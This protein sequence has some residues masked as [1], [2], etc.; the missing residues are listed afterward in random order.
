MAAVIGS[1][2][3]KHAQKEL[4]IDHVTLWSDSQ[5]V[6]HWLSST[7]TL[8]RFVK[9]RVIEIRTLLPEHKWRYCP[10]LDN[11]ADLL[12]RGLSASQFM[13]NE[14]WFKGPSW[15]TDARSWPTWEPQSTTVCLTEACC[16]PITQSSSAD[17]PHVVH[18]VHNLMHLTEYSSLQRLLRVTA[19]VL[20]F[21][22]N[23]RNRSRARPLTVTSSELFESEKQWIASCQRITYGEEIQCITETSSRKTLVKQLKLFIDDSGLLRCGGRIHNAP[24]AETTKFPY[25]LPQKHLFTRLVV[26][27]AH[28]RLLHSGPNATIIFLRQKYWIPAIRRCVQHVLHR[29]VPCRR[30]V[31]KA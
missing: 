30:V 16:D 7:R 17:Y 14:L 19:Y 27:D 25:L 11:P 10:T 9:N 29:C 24:V 21:V 5:I 28:V 13:N 23:C 20:R 2:L 22:N 6:L 3:A 31:G 18:G 15:M 26:Q 4:Q 1:R 12:T 8:P